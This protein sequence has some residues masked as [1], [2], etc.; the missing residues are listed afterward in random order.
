MKKLA[1]IILCLALLIQTS[2]CTTAPVDT[3]S[4][5]TETPTP[6][7]PPVTAF[8]PVA[9]GM[10]KDEVKKAEA[11]LESLKDFDDNWL[12]GETEINKQP[13]KL[14]YRFN[15]NGELYGIGYTSDYSLIDYMIKCYGKY[16]DDY[17]TTRLVPDANTGA[18][19]AIPHSEQGDAFAG[20][21]VIIAS[22]DL[23]DMDITL[24][25][26]SDFEHKPTL[27]SFISKTIDGPSTVSGPPFDNRDITDEQLKKMVDCGEIPANTKILDLSQNQISDLTP[28]QS[29]TELEQLGLGGNLISDVT[30]LQSLTSLYEL[31]LYSNQIDDLAPFQSM[32]NLKILELSKNRIIDITTLESLSKLQKLWLNDNP[33]TYEQIDELRE[34]LPSCIVYGGNIRT[35]TPPIACRLGGQNITDERLKEMIDSEIIPKDIVDMGLSENQIRDLSSLISLTRLQELWL[36]K[37][38]ISDLK[39]LQSFASLVKL[40][41]DDNLISDLESLKPLKQL[42]VLGLAQNKIDDLAPLKSLANLRMLWLGNNQISDITSLKSLK[43]LETLT[44]DDNQISDITLLESLTALQELDLSY[45]EISDITPLKSLMNLQTLLLSGNPLAQEQ[46][47]ELQKALP[48]CEIDF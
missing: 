2:A 13:C 14:Y 26:G 41:L 10:T 21:G 7:E 11:G 40:D 19:E 35:T 18:R 15:D 30:P 31:N 27:I 37:N 23:D 5:P 38:Q 47:D 25:A 16:D 24:E 43:N 1:V 9:F 33:L 45:N 46:I 4:K 42:Q 39:P 8:R 32:T 20:A 12:V 3:N 48:N 28:L 17:F 44:L 29:L 34:A 36:S 6:T 22:W